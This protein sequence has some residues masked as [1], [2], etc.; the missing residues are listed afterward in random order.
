MLAGSAALDTFGDS[1][2]LR[3]VTRGLFHKLFSTQFTAILLKITEFL[4]FMSKFMVKILLFLLIRNLR[5]CKVLW[6]RPQA[7][8]K[9]MECN[10][11]LSIISVTRKNRH[12]YKCL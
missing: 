2:N 11:L 12:V 1:W 4:Q 7:A 5:I 6:N 8:E 3:L 10:Q 9:S